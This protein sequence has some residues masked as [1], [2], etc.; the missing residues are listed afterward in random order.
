MFIPCSPTSKVKG[1]KAISTL[2]WD[3]RFDFSARCLNF[4]SHAG[5]YTHRGGFCERETGN[6]GRDTRPADER[7]AH[8]GTLPVAREGL[9]RVEMSQKLHCIGPKARGACEMGWMPGVGRLP[10]RSRMDDANNP[11]VLAV[12]PLPTAEERRRREI[13]LALLCALGAAASSAKDQRGACALADFT[14]K[15]AGVGRR[16]LKRRLRSEAHLLDDI[17][18]NFP[19]NG[20]V[21]RRKSVA[22]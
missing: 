12:V 18:R 9:S 19:H 15:K 4:R 6:Q 10:V 22:V 20:M 14:L 8:A 5:K 13:T 1:R 21:R 17:W 7:L 11:E 16:D 3:K 2:R